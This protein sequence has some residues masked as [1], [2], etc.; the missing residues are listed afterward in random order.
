[1]HWGHVQ[2]RDL[3]KVSSQG[4]YSHKTCTLMF[5][6]ALHRERGGYCHSTGREKKNIAL[7]PILPSNRNKQ[8][9]TLVHVKPF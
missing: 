3:N 1:M 9:V 5:I 4:D 7:N 2:E 6:I 8:P